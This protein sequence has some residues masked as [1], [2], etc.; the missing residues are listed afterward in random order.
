MEYSYETYFYLIYNFFRIIIICGYIP[1]FLEKTKTRKTKKY[2]NIIGVCCYFII[3]SLLHIYINNPNL[4]LVSN[5]ALFI[6][7]S[8]IFEGKLYMRILC[9]ICVYSLAMIYEGGIYFF[10]SKTTVN[11]DFKEILLSYILSNVFMFITQLILKNKF[12]KNKDNHTILKVKHWFILLIISIS[13]IYLASP[14][15]LAKKWSLYN[16]I[17][18]MV[19]LII[20]FLVFYFF[21]EVKKYYAEVWDKYI[22][23]NRNKYYENQIKVI[24]ASEEA[25]RKLKHDY[26]NHM[27]VLRQYFED[28]NKNS[29]IKYIENITG[30]FFYSNNISE[31]GNIA[32]D[33]LLNY[34]FK[35]YKD[36]N[37]NLKTEITIPAENLFVLD[38]HIDIILGNLLDNAL[39]AVNECDKKDISVVIKYINKALI[40]KV[41]NTFNGIVKKDKKILKTTKK[42]KKNHGY[43]LKNIKRIVK[44]YNGQIDIE[45]T[46][47]KFIVKIFLYDNGIN[48]Q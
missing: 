35:D 8:Y 11:K 4:D 23:E 29:G 1:I 12:N 24:M 39:Y 16:A 25:I 28:N 6:L 14:A 47:N 20:N 18:I 21:Y 22:I 3:N 17:T 19:I 30:D 5:I 9:V 41:E 10:I 34:K 7:Y 42:D 15:V 31:T 40:I 46:E 2:I 48:L 44:L 38:Y 32:I 43:G 45:H 33:S 26:K 36:K 27:I 37:I 13:S